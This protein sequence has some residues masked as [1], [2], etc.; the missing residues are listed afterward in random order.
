MTT[1]VVEWIKQSPVFNS[2]FVTPIIANIS[3]GSDASG[4]IYATYFQ[5]DFLL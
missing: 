1:A 4:N 2:I 3:C 5:S